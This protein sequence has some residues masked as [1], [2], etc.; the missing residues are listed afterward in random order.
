MEFSTA[1]PYRTSVL[2]EGRKVKL[3]TLKPTALISQLNTLE[4]HPIAKEVEETL[5][6]TTKG[7]SE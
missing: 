6:Q 4:L 2:T 7:A 3:G 1:L 5:I